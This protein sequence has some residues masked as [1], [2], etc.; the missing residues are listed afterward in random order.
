[1]NY[2]VI[3]KNGKEKNGLLP[4]KESPEK[5]AK[6]SRQQKNEEVCNFIKNAFCIDGDVTMVESEKPIQSK[7]WFLAQDSKRGEIAIVIKNNK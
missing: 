4:M 7:I 3:A 5:E 1:M 6:K 2:K